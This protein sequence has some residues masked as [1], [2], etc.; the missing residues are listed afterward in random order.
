MI[1]KTMKI[2]IKL[3]KVL[4]INISSYTSTGKAL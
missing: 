1:P 3:S 4:V 2:L